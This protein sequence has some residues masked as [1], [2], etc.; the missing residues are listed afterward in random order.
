MIQSILA[1]VMDLLEKLIMV[2]TGYISFISQTGGGQ[3]ADG[4]PVS[5]VKT[6]SSYVE[7]NLAVI[8]S[9]YEFIVD[10][11][12]K[13]AEYSIYVESDKIRDIDVQSI[14]EIQIHDNNDNDI[15]V[16]QIGNVEYLNLSKK[17]KI[18]V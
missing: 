11:Q 12:Y 8:T 13:Q 6:N 14:K 15:G 3:D 18:I 16:F 4:N 9:K 2:K 10:G 1:H 17:V 7:C 5:P